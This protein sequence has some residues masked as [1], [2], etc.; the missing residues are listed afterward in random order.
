MFHSIRW[1]LILS[2][3][4]LTLLTVV[5]VGALALGLLRQYA[6]RRAEQSLQANAQAIAAQAHPFLAQP[7]IRR[8]ELERLAA[9]AAFLGSVQVR[10]LDQDGHLLVDSNDLDFGASLSLRP[11][12]FLFPETG[13]TFT[14]QS[15]NRRGMMPD[16]G[17]G[18]IITDENGVTG[19]VT[20]HRFPGMFGSRLEFNNGQPDQS[21]AWRDSQ[22]NERPPRQVWQLIYGEGETPPPLPVSD[23][24]VVLPIGDPA[25]PNGFVEL[26]GGPDFVSES[27]RSVRRSFGVAGLGVGLL[28]VIVG[29][30]VSRGLTAPILSLGDAARRMGQGDL[31]ARAPVQSSDEIGQVAAHFNRMADG[32]Q[33]SFAEL[34]AERDALRRFVADASHELRTPITALRSFNELLAG[35]AANDP[36]AQAEFLAESAVQVERLQWITA[37]LLD[38]SRLDGRLVALD[39]AEHDLTDLLEEAAAP[40]RSLAVERGIDLI[41]HAPD[42][43]LVLSC[44]QPRLL[45]ALSNLLDNGLK[46]CVSGDRVELGGEQTATGVCL[47]VADTGPGIDESVQPH[48]FERFYRGRT[49]NADGTE[50]PGS[51]LGLSIVASVV[52][53]HG[54]KIEVESVPGAGSR[55]VIDTSPSG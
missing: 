52:Q 44:D 50:I 39:L 47:W 20:I 5:L 45:L 10:I 7:A 4:A 37:N 35:P 16:I 12:S 23:L 13:F 48:I 41:V 51:G 43:P 33:A 32:L 3:T 34:E 55:F 26:S 11:Q 14:P 8:M 49:H 24:A 46:Y 54:W 21:P 2:Y 53:A 1:R 15:M 27:L 42:A 40:F 18:M 25:A 31:S 28:A 6:Q 22:R 30:L 17:E 29:L 19:I 9:T 36:A 38:L